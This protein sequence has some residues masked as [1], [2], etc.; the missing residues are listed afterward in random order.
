MFVGNRAHNAAYGQAVKIVIDEN[1]TAQND[2][3]QL[4]PDTG[5]NVSLSPTSKSGRTAGFVHQADH[6]AQN[7]QEDQDA[8]V[9]AVGQYRNHAVAEYMEDGSFKGK[10]GIQKSSR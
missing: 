3:G 4:S 5:F 7:H 1:Q 9:V 8:H 10:V 6:A 2:R